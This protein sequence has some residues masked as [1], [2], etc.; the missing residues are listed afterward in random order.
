[1]LMVMLLVVTRYCDYKVIIGILFHISCFLRSKCKW[2]LANEH[3]DIVC[4]H[5][6]LSYIGAYKKQI[7]ILV[8]SFMTNDDA[9]NYLNYFVI[10]LNISV[11]LQ[12]S[13]DYLLI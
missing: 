8:C 2:H 13:Q 12:L 7:F 6:Q 1:M 11:S 3:W 4:H 5:W 9:I 10:Q